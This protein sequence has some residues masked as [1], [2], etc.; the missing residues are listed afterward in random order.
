[1]GG[2]DAQLHRRQGGNFCA[3]RAEAKP[4]ST[5]GY[6]HKNRFPAVFGGQKGGLPWGP[7]KAQA[8]EAPEAGRQPSPAKLLLRLNPSGHRGAAVGPPWGRRGAAVGPLTGAGLGR[9]V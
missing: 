3:H 7:D 1:V 6:E 9:R 2:D 4:F 5:V 8:G